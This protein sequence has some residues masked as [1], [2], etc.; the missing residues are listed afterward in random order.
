MNVNHFITLL[1]NEGSLE[2][3]NK[4]TDS[5]YGPNPHP[6]Y[7]KLAIKWRLGMVWYGMPTFVLNLQVK[8]SII[9]LLVT[10]YR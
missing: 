6:P 3:V 10:N 7:S 8:N 9:V 1:K 5:V 2:V 4:L